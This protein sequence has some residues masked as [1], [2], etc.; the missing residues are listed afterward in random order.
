MV[1]G[2]TGSEHG[3][4]DGAKCFGGRLQPRQ[5]QLQQQLLH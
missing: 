1:V 3:S 5:Q 2:N 4:R